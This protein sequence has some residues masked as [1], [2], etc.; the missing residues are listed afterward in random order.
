MTPVDAIG[1]GAIVDHKRESRRL[2]LCEGSMQRIPL[3]SHP[4]WQQD[5][6]HNGDNTPAAIQDSLFE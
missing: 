3:P 4:A 6:P 1:L 2:M 5:L